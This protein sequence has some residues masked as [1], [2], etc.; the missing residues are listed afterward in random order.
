MRVAI[1]Q[2]LPDGL[3]QALHFR[4]GSPKEFRQVMARVKGVPF[5]ILGHEVP[6]N[7]SYVFSPTQNLPDESLNGVQRSGSLVI[8]SFSSAD[9]F[10]RIEQF[11]IHRRGESRVKQ[12][13]LIR[14]HGVLELSKE[15]QT[16]LDKV[17]QGFDGL[18]TTDRPIKMP[19]LTRVIRET[20]FHRL[21]H[22]LGD[23]VRLEPPGLGQRGRAFFAERLPIVTVVIPLAACG[24]L[25]FHQD[26]ML[27]PQL[28]VKE[29]QPQLFT[30]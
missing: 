25:S 26:L 9:H 12:V 11:Q 13:R 6:I 5:Q 7:S 18:L 24:I 3:L 14:P 17:L 8:S 28:P 27:S 16:I 15:R 23:A 1:I 29:L 30:P 22:I 2:R 4:F 20:T 19:E 10:P 21:E